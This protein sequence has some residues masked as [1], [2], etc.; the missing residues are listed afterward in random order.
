MWQKIKDIFSGNEN[1]EALRDKRI[2]LI[3]DG[4]IE[5]KVYSSAL[6]KAGCIVQTADCAR[7]G[8]ELALTG[9]F[10]LILL[11]YLLPDRNGIE[12][13]RELKSNPQTVDIPIVFLTGSVKPEGVIN[14]YDAGADCYLAKP[15]SAGALIK[16][17]R[18][19]LQQEAAA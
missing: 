13:C 4:E 8:L 19:T 3:D 1:S 10:D 5:R 11:D 14:C 18:M 9:N 2:L 6:I 7:T 12:I 15:I 17:V 16:Q